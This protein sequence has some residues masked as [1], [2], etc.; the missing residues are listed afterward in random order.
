MHGVENFKPFISLRR[1]EIK[2]SGKSKDIRANVKLK[3]SV[4]VTYKLD[5]KKP[6]EPSSGKIEVGKSFESSLSVNI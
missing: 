3:A 1:I 6:G 5:R 2:S 4:V